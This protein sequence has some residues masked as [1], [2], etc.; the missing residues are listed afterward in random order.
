[1]RFAKVSSLSFLLLFMYLTVIRPLGAS[2]IPIFIRSK[3]NLRMTFSDYLLATYTKYLYNYFSR[4]LGW[5]CERKIEDS[6]LRT[7]FSVDVEKM[8]IPFHGLDA[9]SQTM[10]YS[11]H[12]QADQAG[13]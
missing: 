12:Y 9:D 5:E 4:E 13:L 3:S 8:T 2:N 6:L 1:M 11:S 7:L 10:T